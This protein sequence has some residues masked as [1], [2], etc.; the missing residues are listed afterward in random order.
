MASLLLNLPT[1]RVRVP[2]P[3]S[4]L[5]KEVELGVFPKP[6]KIGRR[7][8]W[9]DD[10]IAAMIDAYTAGSN[11]SELRILCKEIHARRARM[12]QG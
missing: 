12:T 10:E 3:R 9:R 5:Y 1:V 11:E 6:I 8:F 7:S 2:R 4:G